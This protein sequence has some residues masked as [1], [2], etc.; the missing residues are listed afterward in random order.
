MIHIHVYSC[1]YC[2]TSQSQY[3]CRYSTIL[4]RF[5]QHTSSTSPTSA[6]DDPHAYALPWFWRRLA[7]RFEPWRL[8]YAYQT[9]LH[10]YLQHTQK[11]QRALYNEHISFFFQTA[12]RFSY[13]RS[14]YSRRWRSHTISPSYYNL[15]AHD[16]HAWTRQQSCM[17]E[18]SK[19]R[20][21][22]NRITSR[23]R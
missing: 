6:I 5:C 8:S 18:M 21:A 19:T 20:P 12:V 4:F 13:F 22:S 3:T 2:T 17:G 15:Q 16:V 14:S 23:H 9:T 10:G 1:M 11:Q 7:D